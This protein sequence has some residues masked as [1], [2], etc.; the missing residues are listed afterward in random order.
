MQINEKFNGIYLSLT[1]SPLW[2]LCYNIKILPFLWSLTLNMKHMELT[3]N[4]HEWVN[5]KVKRVI[6][7]RVLLNCLLFLLIFIF[8]I[9]CI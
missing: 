7:R 4:T 9:L 2:L 1:H 3:Q 6:M 5:V 8:G